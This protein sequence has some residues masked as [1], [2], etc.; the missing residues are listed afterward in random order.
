MQHYDH[1]CYRKEELKI[2]YEQFR[3]AL[4]LIAKRKY[5]KE[6]DEAEEQIKML[7]KKILLERNRPSLKDPSVSLDNTSSQSLRMH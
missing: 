2:S 5:R 6:S 1:L 7:E 4:R 3:S